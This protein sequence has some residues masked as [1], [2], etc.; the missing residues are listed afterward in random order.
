MKIF[1][2]V[3]NNMFV[4]HILNKK[5]MDSSQSFINGVQPFGVIISQGPIKISASLQMISK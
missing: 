2:E 3:V 4:I 5:I 1:G